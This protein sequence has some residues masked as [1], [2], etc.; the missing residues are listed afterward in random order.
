MIARRE[1]WISHAV[2]AV[3][4]LA[5]VLPVIGVVILALE[6]GNPADS[7]LTLSH[8]FTFSNF[9]SAWQI[10]NGFGSYLVTS[11]IVA[12]VSVAGATVLS[13][14]AGYAFGTMEFRGKKLLTSMLLLGL[15]MPPRPRSC[16]SSTTCARS[17]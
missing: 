1:V 11:A 5:A 9:S 15:I 2:L 10:G 16:H 7:T 4:A 17:T 14:L 6:P 3:F 13:V 12:V 8:G